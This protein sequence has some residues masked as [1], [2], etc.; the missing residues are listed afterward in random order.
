MTNVCDVRM[1]GGHG[2]INLS[3]KMFFR[4]EWSPDTNEYVLYVCVMWCN[5]MW[6]WSDMKWNE[7]DDMSSFHVTT[8]FDINALHVSVTPTDRPTIRTTTLC[9]DADTRVCVYCVLGIVARIN[10]M[11]SVEMLTIKIPS[12]DSIDAK[13]AHA[14]PMILVRNA[15]SL[16]TPFTFVH[17]IHHSLLTLY[18]VDTMEIVCSKMKIVP[19]NRGNNRFY[20]RYILAT[21]QR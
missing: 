11:E 17:S 10:M 1:G 21:T 4:F 12:F 9:T 2:H 18:R 19:L 3:P 13:Q 14:F 15:P 6:S 8:L 20:N 5:V 16:N 7:V